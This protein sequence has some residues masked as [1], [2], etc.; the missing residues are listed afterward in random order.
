[1]KAR[2]SA[3]KAGSNRRVRKEPT[4]AYLDTSR[5]PSELVLVVDDVVTKNERHRAVTIRGSKKTGK[6]DRA[7]VIESAAADALKEAVRAAVDDAYVN[8]G[9][10][11]ITTGVWRL[12]VL[13]VWPT[14]RHLADGLDVPFGDSDSPLGLIRDALQHAGAIDNDIR[15]VCDRTAHI[16]EKGERR[17]LARLCLANADDL[18]LRNDLLMAERQSLAR[19]RGQPVVGVAQ[20][21]AVGQRYLEVFNSAG[22]QTEWVVQAVGVTDEFFIDGAVVLCDIADATHTI[23]ADTSGFLKSIASGQFQAVTKGDVA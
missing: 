10:M 20:R 3:A 21:I 22:G 5:W 9:F 13:S 18:R 2:S 15:V 7:S 14:Q 8:R 12:E 4:R 17:T 1:V 19:M 11:G 16:Y 23:R 6:K